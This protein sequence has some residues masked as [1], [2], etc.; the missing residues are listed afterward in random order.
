MAAATQCD[1]IRDFAAATE[2]GLC[3]ARSCRTTT[4][5]CLPGQTCEGGVCM[6]RPSGCPAVLSPAL[7]AVPGAANKRMLLFATQYSPAN[8]VEG[9]EDR[10]IR[11]QIERD[12]QTGI[13]SAESGL[14]AA[15]PGAAPGATRISWPD[16]EYC[17][18]NPT[19]APGG[20]F[21]RKYFGRID[22]ESFG[23]QPTYP[24]GHSLAQGSVWKYPRASPLPMTVDYLMNPDLATILIVAFL[25]LVIAALF[26]AASSAEKK[27][28]RPAPAAAPTLR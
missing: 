15:Y 11:Q 22:A 7:C 19:G 13:Q 12:L 24:I 5:D 10:A 21:S 14:A 1:I 4:P 23:M 3:S 20:P 18:W 8:L 25:V 26:V 6:G 28:G 27:R 2:C 9:A 16:F 17:L